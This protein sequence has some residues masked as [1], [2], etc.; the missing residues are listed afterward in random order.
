MS[1]SHATPTRREVL[2][3][4]AMT[5]AATMIPTRLYAAAGDGDIRPFQVNIPEAV[6]TD[7]RRRV[8]ATRPLDKGRHGHGAAATRPAAAPSVH[9]V[10]D[11]VSHD[12]C[13]RRRRAPVPHAGRE[14]EPAHEG[15]FRLVRLDDADGGRRTC[16]HE[17]EL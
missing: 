2:V 17:R 5:G 8:A 3:A 16:A 11:V 7:L 4:A 14:R 12:R 9:V 13:W 1:E 6:L 10:H 15:R